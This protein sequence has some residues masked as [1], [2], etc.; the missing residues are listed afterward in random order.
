MALRS[1]RVLELA[2]LAPVPYCGQV[3]VD[4][5]AEVVR[6]DRAGASFNMDQQSRGKKSIALNLK[7][8]SGQNILRELAKTSDVLIDPFRPGV[9]E[10]LNCGPDNIDNDK[11]I[12]AR[13]SG[14][15]QTGPMRDVAGHD[16]N[17]L[18]QAGV[19]DSLRDA[20]GRPCPPINLVADFAGG[21]LMMALGITAALFER[22]ATGQGQILDLA[23][24]EGAAYA[25]GFLWSM[26]SLFP[27]EKGRNMLDGG[28]PFYRV[29]ETSDNKWMAVGSIEPQ[30]YHEL[31]SR[32]DLSN[33]QLPDQ[34]DQSRWDELE[35]I[36]EKTFKSKCQNDWVAIFDKSD[37]CVSPVLTAVEA[38]N[39]EHNKF[40]ESFL[41]DDDGRSF[42][43]AAPRS[44]RLVGTVPTAHPT[45]GQHTTEIL[46]ELF[47][48]NEI[49]DFLTLGVAS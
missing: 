11:L 16:I 47:S 31:I 37:A 34:M 32:L 30:F 4:Y 24:S 42:P 3:L 46:S 17:Y 8:P 40:R 19:L 29:Y 27:N 35:E 39:D 18:A 21:G 45:V 28:A 1:V 12:F 38:A 15:G 5:G 48:E 26:E 33:H 13:L 44:D 20:S 49:S 10:R 22:H 7:S 43:A 36:F 23:M 14:F 41:V 25:S 6:V 2:G 9:L